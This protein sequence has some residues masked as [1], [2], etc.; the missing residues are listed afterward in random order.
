MMILVQL[1]I[2]IHRLLKTFLLKSFHLHLLFVLQRKDFSN[3]NEEEENIESIIVKKQELELI[4]QTYNYGDFTTNY[5]TEK[6]VKTKR[7]YSVS[8]DTKRR[9]LNLRGGYVCEMCGEFESVDTTK[10]DSHH[11]IP[12]SMGGIDNVYNT[13][14]LCGTCHDIMHSNIPFTY[15]QTWKMLKTVRKNISKTKPHY[16]IKFDELFDPEYNYHYNNEFNEEKLLEQ[17]KKEEDYYNMHK[18][19]EDKKFLMMWNSI[20]R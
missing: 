2:H 6:K 18:E 13:V 3:Y 9:T 8:L 11:I 15:E 12:L 7:S 1:L 14:C 16:L 10:F 20:K 19:E 17:Y 4:K 5:D